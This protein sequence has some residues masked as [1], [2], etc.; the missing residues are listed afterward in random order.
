M[1]SLTSASSS[2]LLVTH[3]SMTAVAAIGS[4]WIPCLARSASVL[5]ARLGCPSRP[6]CLILRVA[7]ISALVLYFLICSQEKCG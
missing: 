3:A 1:R 5:I 4:G 6:Y 7:S 2:L